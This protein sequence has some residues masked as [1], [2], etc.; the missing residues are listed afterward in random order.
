[1]S[2]EELLENMAASKPEA[3]KIPIKAARLGFVFSGQ[4]SQWQ[5]MG[6]ELMH[7]FPV[8]ATIIEQ[9]DACL[10]RLGA[11]WCLKGKNIATCL[12]TVLDFA[13]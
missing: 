4:G 6:Q 3:K 11:T 8:F 7:D 2:Q 13:C 10:Q 9:S 12:L 5:A 1:M